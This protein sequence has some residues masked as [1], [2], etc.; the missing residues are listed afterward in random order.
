[1]LRFAAHRRL[2]LAG[3]VGLVLAS[4]PSLRLPGQQPLKADFPVPIELAPRA[5][6]VLLPFGD[7][8]AVV[9]ELL[10]ANPSSRTLVVERIE[11]VSE[12]V[13]LAAW[14]GDEL[15]ARAARLPPMESTEEAALLLEPGDRY[16]LYMWLDSLDPTAAPTHIGHQASVR[17]GDTGEA[18]RWSLRTRPAPVE[19]VT[20]V[21]DAP[22][23]GG[24]WLVTNGLSNDADHRR[25]ITASG[26]LFIPQRFGADFLKL[27]SDGNNATAERPLRNE[28]FHAFEEPLYA[29]ADGEVVA[30]RRGLPD[31]EAG[32][33]PGPL[34]WGEVP[35]NHV[36]I[37]LGNGVF[38]LYAHLRQGS[39]EVREGQKVTRGQRI[40][41]IGNSGNTS[42]PHLHFHMMDGPAPN[43]AEGV[44]FVFSSFDLLVEGYRFSPD[45]LPFPEEGARRTRSLPRRGWVVRF[46]AGS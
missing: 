2:L 42:A 23:R 39:I 19:R 30:V 44:P 16:V 33:A 12:D 8:S 21:I 10:V 20:T 27:G 46:P 28:A 6:I 45:Q 11:A 15:V 40:A 26:E 41:R 3:L 31:N 37:R 29:V 24:R 1:M 9:Y 43:L 14:E 4:V 38:A 13:A 18:M 22:V 7:Q 25:F 5:R 36:V 17:T 32:S 34:A 35:G